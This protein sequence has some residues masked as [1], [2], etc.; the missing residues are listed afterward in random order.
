M[1]IVESRIQICEHKFQ[2]QSGP[3]YAIVAPMQV[4]AKCT[5]IVFLDI[6]TAAL[7]AD[8][9]PV[10]WSRLD[11]AQ[12]AFLDFNFNDKNGNLALESFILG[13]WLADRRLASD[14]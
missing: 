5:C 9:L 11:E 7:A 12:V 3:P 6:P 2:G 4:N 10:E 13:N 14:F 8:A 1:I